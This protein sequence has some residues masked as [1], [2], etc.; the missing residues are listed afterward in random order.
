MGDA[1]FRFGAAMNYIYPE[2]PST[3]NSKRK[4][5]RLSNLSQPRWSN[6]SSPSQLAPSSWFSDTDNEKV[7][8]MLADRRLGYRN[9]N[10]GVDTVPWTSSIDDHL[11][12]AV[13]DI[14]AGA[15]PNWFELINDSDKQPDEELWEDWM[16]E[17][18]TWLGKMG[19][20]DTELTAYRLLHRL[21][22]RY[23]PRLFGVVRVCINSESTP[24]HLITDVVEG[25]ALEYI[26]S[27]SME[28]L[29]SGIDVSEQEAERVSSEVL[30]GLR[31]IEAENYLLHDDV[32]TRNVVVPEGN[33][34]AVIIDFGQAI[35]RTERSDEEWLSVIH[36]GGIS[37]IP[38]MAGGRR[39]AVTPFNMSNWHYKKPLAF[40]KYVESMP[41]DFRRATFDRV[42][43]TDWEGARE[44]VDQ[45]RIKPGV[46]RRPDHDYD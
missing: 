19:C 2:R 21:Q 37:W 30:E 16:F 39:A 40:N 13:R 28:N 22:G 43:D 17:V 29:K 31:A 14:Q 32:H 4:A 1:G 25:L 41:E 24:L 6:G 46:H 35:I 5:P 42:L 8:L 36:G 38:S 26:P 9:H 44:K 23:M 34:S 7:I 18:G 12:R 15:I 3:F 45:W 20:Y 33:R 27:V 11:R 10:K